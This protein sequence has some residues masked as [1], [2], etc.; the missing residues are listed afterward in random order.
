MQGGG[1]T[2][3]AALALL[4][5]AEGAD[6][7]A[8]MRA[9]RRLARTTHPDVS[10]APDAEVRF[11]ALAAAYRRALVGAAEPLLEPDPSPRVR[12]SEQTTRADPLLHRVGTTVG[13]RRP[14][15]VTWGMAVPDFTI[16]VGPVRVVPLA[17]RQNRSDPD[18]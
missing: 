5:L 14:G 17:R 16:V 2:R 12:V 1:P 10:D 6:R 9:Y 8:V 11:T 18:G 7:Q 15:P 13:V 4:G 3:R